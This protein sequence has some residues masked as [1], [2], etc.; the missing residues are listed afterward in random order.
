MALGT[1]KANDM[2]EAFT[3]IQLQDKLGQLREGLTD[4]DQRVRSIVQE[5]PFV[6]VLGAL[7]TGYFL[8][9]L[10]ARR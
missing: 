1:N 8:G 5:R 3:P 7:A 9:R 4:T 10:I 6:A 2:T